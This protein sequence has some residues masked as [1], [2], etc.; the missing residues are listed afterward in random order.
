MDQHQ[1]RALQT[2][3]KLE[4]AIL[5]GLESRGFSQKPPKR[6]EIMRRQRRQHLP[7]VNHVSL[8][9]HDAIERLAGTPLSVGLQIANGHRDLVKQK[10]D[11]Q[12]HLLVHDDEQHLVRLVRYG[13]LRA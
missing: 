10:L 11:P 4:F 3:D 5:M 12:F 7:A 9:H 2:Q 6:C 13:H 1:V 8:N